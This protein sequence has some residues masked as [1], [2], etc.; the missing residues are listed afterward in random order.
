MREKEILHNWVLITYDIPRGKLG[1][2]LR[3]WLIRKLRE[4]GAMPYTESVWYLPYSQKAYEA[5]ERLAGRAKFY[6]WRASLKEREDAKE[7]TRK[8]RDERKILLATL[9][10]LIDKYFSISEEE[11][12]ISK[13]KY[14]RSMILSI[15]RCIEQSL[16]L[17][18]DEEIAR[19]FT[20]I[21]LP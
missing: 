15:Q 7:L 12:G 20:Q 21:R 6:V 9:R 8:Y 18:W 13:L 1:H 14:Y 5:I 2:A 3:H 10:A 4:L 17:D 16:A 19:E 11:G